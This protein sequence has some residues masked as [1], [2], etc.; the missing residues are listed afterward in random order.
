MRTRAW[1]CGSCSDNPETTSLNK[2]VV[3]SKS[4]YCFSSV[5]FSYQ[6]IWIGVALSIAAAIAVAALYQQYHQ[7]DTTVIVGINSH[8]ESN[9][10]RDKISN[11]MESAKSNMNEANATDQSSLTVNEQHEAQSQSSNV[12]TQVT[13]V[14]PTSKN[15]SDEVVVSIAFGG[16]SMLYFN[17]CPRL[18]QQMLQAASSTH[19][20]VVQDSCLRGGATLSSLWTNGNGM[21][22]KF[23][24]PAAEIRSSNSNCQGNR[25]T[26][27]AILNQDD[28]NEGNGADDYNNDDNECSGGGSER[29]RYDVG[30]PTVQD[31]LTSRTAGWNVVVLNDYTQGPARQHSRLESIHVLEHRYAPLLLQT[32]VTMIVLIQTP[33]YQHKGIKDSHDLGDF[34]TFSNKLYNGVASYAQALEQWFSDHS[35]TSSSSSSSSLSSKPLVRVAPVGEAFRHLYRHNRSLWNKLYS[36]DHFHPSPHGTWLQACVLYLTM[37]PN[38]N[39]DT[40][41]NYNA[42]WWDQSRVMQPADEEPLPRPTVPEAQELSRVAGLVCRVEPE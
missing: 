8:M 31:M 37:Y 26:A 25:R 12:A 10:T 15:E 16:N 11:H 23:A 20:T 22:T 14:V 34:E 40:V 6:R 28:D 1:L 41:P 36:W 2:R 39:A 33:A 32:N 24:T 30:S 13:T 29:V 42:S 21:G 17:D 9:S 18:V 38:S 7:N 3:S 19:N 5:T 4:H 27:S 35:T